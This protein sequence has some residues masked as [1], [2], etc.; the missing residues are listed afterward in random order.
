MFGSIKLMFDIL[1]KHL[2]FVGALLKHNVYQILYFQENLFH[3]VLF[4]KWPYICI[5]TH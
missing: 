3:S 4:W 5:V 1:N 2:P